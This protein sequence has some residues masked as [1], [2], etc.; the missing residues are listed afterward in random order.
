MDEQLDVVDENDR[1][2]GKATR[3]EC[4]AKGHIHRCVFFFILDKKGRILVTQ[5]T[6]EKEFYPEYW[7][8]LIGGHVSSGES[9]EQAVLREAKEEAGIEGHPK[10]LT[11]YKK[12]TDKDKENIKVFA[13]ITDNIPRLDPKELKQGLFL[14]LDKTEEKI[15][16]EK[17]LPETR[18]MLKILKDFFSRRTR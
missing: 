4:H 5:R 6:K 13:F 1:I 3:K 14:S 2:I 18:D 12:R 16:Q 11:S 9:Y 10:L 7:S 15:K 17:F 8:I